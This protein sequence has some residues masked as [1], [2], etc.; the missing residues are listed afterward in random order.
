MK[1]AAKS[2]ADVVA[3]EGARTTV[4]R[5]YSVAAEAR[6]WRIL[7][8]LAVTAAIWVVFHQLTDGVYI[9]PRNLSNLSVQLT[10][11]A[12]AAAGMTALLIS[13]EID[14]SAGSLYA[15]VT[16]LTVYVQVKYRW[17]AVEA[18][19]L[20]LLIG[21]AVGAF[22]GIVTTRLKIPS[23]IV[24]LA[25]FTFLQG[26]AYAISGAEVLS[27]TSDAFVRIANGSIPRDL[28]LALGAAVFAVWLWIWLKPMRLLQPNAIGRTALAELRPV[29]VLGAL[30]VAGVLSVALWAFSNH[31]GLPYPVAILAVVVAL[32]LFVA[33]STPFGRHVYAIGGSP[34]AAR[35]SGIRVERVGLVLF[36][37]MG[38]LT[39]LAGIIQASR[40]DAGPPSVGPFL[41]L[42]A[43]SA[44]VVG[45][46]S[47]F[48]GV[49]SLTGTLIGT[50]LLASIQNGL[51][52]MGINTF[53]Q[54]MASGTILL[55]V[56]AID[57]VARR[58][59]RRD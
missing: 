30:A 4:L 36:C 1:T 25:G 39:A 54:Y 2:T 23:F 47:L 10:M 29:T 6:I 21:L 56:V 12:L 50:L 44:A 19:A 27:G 40:L 48:G 26:A 15:V 55:V 20:G 53:Y 43:I 3:V 18:V 52:L 33:G 8:L 35:R 37:A 7:V 32:W 9:S 46:T 57:S 38:V 16:V 28:T 42:D 59:V 5:A 51:S 17:G 11:T 41:A 14:L 24:T 45:G 58:R 49:G 34:E 13:R 22:Q 31:R